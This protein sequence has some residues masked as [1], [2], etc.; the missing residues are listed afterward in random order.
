[1]WKDGAGIGKVRMLEEDLEM[2]AKR[3]GEDQRLGPSMT[4]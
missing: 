2:S 4:A 3:V 1:M